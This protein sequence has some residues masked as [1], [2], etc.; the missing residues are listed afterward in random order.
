VRYIACVDAACL[1]ETR[2][3]AFASDALAEAARS[4][5]EQHV[6]DCDSCRRLLAEL[7]RQRDSVTWGPDLRVGRYVVRQRVGRGGMGIVWRSAARSP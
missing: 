2:A 3:L 7:V 4:S 6:D 5:V 1:D